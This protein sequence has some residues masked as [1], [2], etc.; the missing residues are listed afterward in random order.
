M[1]ETNRS[2]KWKTWTAAESLRNDLLP[3]L[4][5]GSGRRIVLSEL[6][7]DQK[8]AELWRPRPRLGCGPNAIRGGLTLC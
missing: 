5:V 2:R 8:V 6:Q 4:A 7:A 3:T 1:S